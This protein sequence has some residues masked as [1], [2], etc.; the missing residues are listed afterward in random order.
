[1]I[2]SYLGLTETLSRVRKQITL[3]NKIDID[4][5]HFVLSQW[6]QMG[7]WYTFE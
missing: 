3:V 2:A 5:W 1:M 6:K 4:Q 7:S